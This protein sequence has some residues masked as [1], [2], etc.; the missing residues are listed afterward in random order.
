MKLA[1]WINKK[2]LNLKKID[3]LNREFRSNK[4]FS[5][6]ELRGFF[7]EEKIIC[8]IKALSSVRFYEKDADLFHFFQTN[9]ISSE[10]NKV[11]QDFRSFLCSKEFLEYMH[12]V[13]ELSF[14]PKTV[15][16]AGT[17]YA[18]THYLLCHDDQLE[19]RN[20]A[21][22]LYLSSLTKK[23][24]GALNLMDKKQ[25]VVKSLIPKMNT[26]TFFHVSPISFHEVSEVVTDTQRIALGGWLHDK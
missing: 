13:T 15:D 4:P 26:L 9:D 14:K 22:L 5:H 8:L 17:L 12:D 3:A 11:L 24:G 25:R 20:I 10:K 21:F 18:N 19:G 23:D 16:L 7:V 2:Y 1:D 6:L